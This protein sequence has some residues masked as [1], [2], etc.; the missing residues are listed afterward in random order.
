TVKASRVLPDRDKLAIA[1]VDGIDPSIRERYGDDLTVTQTVSDLTAA[2]TKGKITEYDKA[3]AIQAYFANPA[4]KFVYD[5]KASQP[6]TKGGDPLTAFLT[7]KHGFC[8]Q[9]AT[10]MA[11]M[12]RVAGIPSRVAVG[13]TT[14]SQDTKD[15]TLY[16]ITTSDAHAWPEA[17]FAGTGW[18]RFEP[19]PAASGSSVPAYT[20]PAVV[21]PD[22][23]NPGRLITTTPTPKAPGNKTAAQKD[24]DLLNRLDGKGGTTLPSATSTRSGRPSLW[25]PLGVLVA[26]GLVLPVV[27]TQ[28]RRRR[29]WHTPGPRTAWDQL[30]DDATD[31]G[32][33][34]HPSESPRI[35]AQRLAQWRHLPGP[36]LTALTA[37]A[38]A[39]EQARYAPP[40]RASGADLRPQVALVR[41]TLQ[42]G[43]P[44]RTR[45]KALLFPRS[46]WQWAYHGL[47]ERLADVLDRLD[48][49]ISA[50]TRPLRRRTRVS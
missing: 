3:T 12:L 26:L 19:T 5:L 32:Y 23:A 46:T 50:V 27:L 45:A 34:W 31:V 37:L 7:G 39:A 13:F 47:G 18:V 10:A 43:S 6:T 36:A 8:E 49:G 28:V 35:A 33:R 15:K 2:I 22:P 29:R 14:G 1:Q 9:Y 40:G 41:A 11:V 4:N 38:T 16:T 42:E 17:W 30:V 25:L 44:A 24:T 21:V 20:I 48:D